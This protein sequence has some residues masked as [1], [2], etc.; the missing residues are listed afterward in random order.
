MSYIPDTTQKMKV[1]IYSKRTDE[2]NPYWY[3]ILEGSDAEFVRGYDWAQKEF[4]MMLANIID[5]I[6]E[7]YSDDE[8]DIER[9]DEEKAEEVNEII[10]RYLYG[11][12]NELVVSMIESMK[13]EDYD[14]R[15]EAV[16]DLPE[17]PEYK[18]E[19]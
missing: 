9:S 17:D 15:F 13:Q 18:W 8:E 6:S 5:E 19:D 11:C 1:D 3:K 2:L 16:K 7:V 14:R 12:R 4:D 10:G